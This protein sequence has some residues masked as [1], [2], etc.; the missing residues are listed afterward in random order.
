M[1]LEQSSAKLRRAE[2]R[3]VV[4]ISAANRRNRLA[5]NEKGCSNASLDEADKLGNLVGMA[6]LNF[7][8]SSDSDSEDNSWSGED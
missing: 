1:E 8:E 3:A 6:T 4:E 5:P 2:T 7:C